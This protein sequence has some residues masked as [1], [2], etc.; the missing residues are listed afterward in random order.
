MA[1]DR[2][3]ELERRW[4]ESGAVDDEA[5]WLLER[6]RVGGLEAERLQLAAYCGHAGARVALGSASNPT[7]TPVPLRSYQPV[8]K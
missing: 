7:W 5:A 3:R 4:K 8:S 2:L 1:D 6:V